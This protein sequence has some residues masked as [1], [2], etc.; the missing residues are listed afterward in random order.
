[1]VTRSKAPKELLNKQEKISCELLTLTYG[2]IVGQIVKDFEDV[3]ECNK[4]L[5]NLGYKMGL[6][7]VEEFL[8]K[9]G[10]ESCSDFRQT[11]ETI[12]KPAFKMFLGITCEVY[13]FVDKENCFS[14][15]MPDNPLVDYVELP[16]HLSAL[17][18][19]NVICGVIRGAL[20][21]VNYKVKCYFVKDTLMG[22]DVTEIKIEEIKEI[23]KKKKDDDEDDD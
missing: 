6:K 2:A 21:A 7:L 13:N 3:Q 9:S 17:H 1:M 20:E 18:Y 19:S 14:L 16:K 5:E 23:I 10:V 12:A 8:A 4:Q 11:A 15:I 22:D